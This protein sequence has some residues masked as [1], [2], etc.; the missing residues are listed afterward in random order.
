M[1]DREKTKEQLIGQVNELRRE[2]SELETLEKERKQTGKRLAEDRELLSVTLQ[3][4]GDG[5]ITTDTQGKIT[6]IN[7]EAEKL[8]GW[9]NE[10]AL[11]RPLTEVFHIVNEQT[12]KPC[13]D[14]VKK[15]IETGGIVG[16]ANHTALI[17]KDGT[18]RLIADSGAPIFDNDGAI[19]GA[20]LVF[21]DETEKRR[22]EN[23]LEK[24]ERRFRS[25]YESMTEGVCLHQVMYDESGE[26][27]D[28]QI[29]EVNTS[30]EKITGL[31]KAD[32]VG[33]LASEIYG[34]GTPPYFDVYVQVAQTGKPTLFE[35]YFPPMDKHF[36]IRA[37]CPGK[38]M[39]AT[40]FE[41]IT[42]RNRAVEALRVS[43][44]RFQQIVENAVEWIWEV[45]ADG[46]YTYSSA[47]VEKILGYTPEE[48]VGKKHFFD[49]FHPK[50]RDKMVQAARDVF[51]E[52]RPFREFPNLNVHKNGQAVWLLTSGVPILS[53]N[54]ELV[55]YRG[56]D[57]DIT[58]SKTAEEELVR[59]AQE[60][61][62]LNDILTHD[63]NNINQAALSYL[64]LLLLPESEPLTEEQTILTAGCKKQIERCSALVEKAKTISLM[65]TAK[66]ESLSRMN[67][68]SVLS[69]AVK[70][71]E[72]TKFEKTFQIELFP[73]DDAYIWADALLY[74][75]FLN[76]IENAVKHAAGQEVRIAIFVEEGAIDETP[77]WTVRVEDNGPGIRDEFKPYIFNRFSSTKKRM[78]S[79]LGLGIVSV[80]LERYEGRISVADRVA[81]DHTKGCRFVVDFKKA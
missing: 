48:L 71:A 52:K 63:I 1:D 47:M 41:D 46:L 72:T 44:E 49:M 35:T 25:L 53:K 55:G 62:L 66:R 7:G 12:R 81:G 26:P 33:K 8:T 10:E 60:I 42:E 64:N 5:V 59:S 58:Q 76:L 16:L 9:S 23:A 6:L 31:K 4:I 69:G 54:G 65:K 80:L 75:L 3:S 40:V 68:S 50:D 36:A 77:G 18:E 32:A 17:A 79:G 45:D 13:S 38:G 73:V 14:P 67:L 70:A 21:R 51:A 39:F 56:A 24:S 30:Y 11:G 29:L 37:F 57:T 19:R 20:V 34:T 15:A 74:Q 61:E 2:L 78:G 27:T 43:E 22:A 28:Y